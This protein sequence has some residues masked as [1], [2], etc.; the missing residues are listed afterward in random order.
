V[1]LY[2]LLTGDRL[3]KGD[4]TADT[5]AQVLT[6][7]P[8]LE[9]VPAKARRLMRR[10]LEKDSKQRLR[11]IGEARHFL[12]SETE[13]QPQKTAQRYSIILPGNTT[14]LHTF[15]IS[16]DGRLLVIA[17]TVNGRRQLW[18]RTLDAFHAP[19]MPGT[20]DAIYPFWSPDSRYIG[21]FAQGKL[22][23]IAVSGGPPQSLCDALAG[24][25]GSWSRADV[26]V[27]SHLLGENAIQRVSAAGGVPADVTKAKGRSEFPVFL[28]DGRHFLYTVLEGS[29]EGN[30]V[31][32]SSLDGKENRRVLADDSSVFFAAGRPLFIREN[33]LVAQPFDAASGQSVGEVL[34]VAKGFSTR[35][36]SYWP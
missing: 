16:P 20:D 8:D 10:C 32:L 21:F 5:L 31:Y 3:F 30:G 25:G 13:G 24:V 14:N 22:K 29:V 19:A 2:E 23:K 11:D 18:L 9:R 28:P 1:V 27:F 26:I 33:T 17:A 12:E 34:P 36:L 4:E 35:I 6:K 7:E 15:A